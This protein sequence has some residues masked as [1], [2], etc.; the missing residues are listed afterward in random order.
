MA[1]SSGS[2]A[3]FLTAPN[4]EHHRQPG[5]RGPL[6][7]QIM[8]EQPPAAPFRQARIEMQRR[9]ADDQ[10]RI[11][12]FEHFV[13]LGRM[14]PHAGTQ[15]ELARQ[16]DLRQH[17]RRA[18]A[19]IGGDGLHFLDRFA[20]EEQ[21]AAHRPPA[22][23]RA[24]GQH[25]QVALTGKLDRR[26]ES[27]VRLAR[28]QFLGALRRNTEMHVEDAALRTMQESPHQRRR[29]QKADCGNAAAGSHAE[30]PIV[31]TG[32]FRQPGERPAKAGAALLVKHE[33]FP[34]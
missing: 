21:D 31:S 32:G 17:D 27:D 13:Q 22:S 8:D 28:A 10:R 6:R 24:T 7:A 23:H 16:P 1:G 18:R 9:I 11:G 26:D 29:V 19:R 15:T 14:G 30:K 34:W 25:H 2:A 33:K 5:H 20:A 4:R 12:Q 3:G